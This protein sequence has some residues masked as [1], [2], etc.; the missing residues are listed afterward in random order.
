MTLCV[1]SPFY[2][3]SFLQKPPSPSFSPAARITAKKHGILAVLLLV[4][5][6]KT[7]Q[8]VIARNKPGND[9]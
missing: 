1:F 2:Y 7:S 6:T 8:P 5:L 9:E 3:S 4:I